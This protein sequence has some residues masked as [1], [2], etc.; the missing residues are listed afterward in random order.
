MKA[1][2][3]V[4]PYR[5]KP[6]LIREKRLCFVKRP[7][8]ALR[9]TFV[10]AAYFVSTPLSSGFARLALYTMRCRALHLELFTLPSP[11]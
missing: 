1:A 10:A 4:P 2:L 11:F 7:S 6:D 8:A 3:R 9:F 5:K